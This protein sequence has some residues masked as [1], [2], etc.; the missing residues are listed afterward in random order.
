MR[1]IVKYTEAIKKLLP[2]AKF[3]L[4]GNDE[5]S[6]Q[7]TSW[8]DETLTKPTHT[9][10]KVKIAELETA[11]DNNAYQRTRSAAY[12]E[13]K[14]QLD[15]LYHDMAADKGDKTGEWFKAVKKVKDDNPKE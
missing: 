8:E 10:I 15:L 1:Y 9:A 7:I 5:N 13:L 6:I 4:S 2:T 11:Y 14:E 3:G 12:L